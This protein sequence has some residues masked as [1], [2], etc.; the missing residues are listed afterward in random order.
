MPK[1]KGSTFCIDCQETLTF[2]QLFAHG[3]MA[4]WCNDPKCFRFGLLT[5][6]ST[7][8]GKSEKYEEKKEEDKKDGDKK[9]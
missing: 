6:L 9:V 7:P 2:A 5:V 3:E 8:T 1:E 4:M